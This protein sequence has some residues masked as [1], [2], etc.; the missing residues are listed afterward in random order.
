MAGAERMLAGF[1]GKLP[2]RPDFVTRGLPLAFVERWHDWIGDAMAAARDALGEAWLDA[3]LYAP[4]WRFVLPP[5][6][7]GESAMAGTLMPSVDAV[8]RYFPLTLVLPLPSIAA[9]ASM[10]VSG[11]SWFA[12]AETLSLSALEEDIDP[13]VLNERLLALALPP[14]Q[15]GLSG[16]DQGQGLVP[17]GTACLVT[18]DEEMKELLLAAKAREQLAAGNSVWWTHGSAAVPAAI[19]YAVGLPAPPSFAAMLNG[20]WAAHGWAVTDGTSA[21]FLAAD[22][23][24]RRE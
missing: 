22:E 20:N 2:I 8:G 1:C 3:Y 4:I 19:L 7:A 24:R 9:A 12:D 17:P 10:L 15:T 5:G 6:L 16:D 11:E 14:W 21:Q 18:S 23:A 13:E